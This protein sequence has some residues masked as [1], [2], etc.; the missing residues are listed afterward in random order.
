L[1][2]QAQSTGIALDLQRGRAKGSAKIIFGH[3]KWSITEGTKFSLG[4]SPLLMTYCP[5]GA[6]V[7]AF[8]CLQ[9]F[10]PS[11][12]SVVKPNLF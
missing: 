5:A 4:H 11:A 6:L 9:W 8:A 1:S 2:Y 10:Y 7:Y 12:I 3:P